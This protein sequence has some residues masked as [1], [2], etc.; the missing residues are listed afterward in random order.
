MIGLINE[1]KKIENFETFYPCLLALRDSEIFGS[2][3]PKQIGVLF[4]RVDK[5]SRSGIS[6]IK[7]SIVTTVSLG[8]NGNRIYYSIKRIFNIFRK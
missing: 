8:E 2:F 6:A 7:F 1:G 3:I 5:S 4:H